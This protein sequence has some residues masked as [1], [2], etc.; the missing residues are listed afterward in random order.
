MWSLVIAKDLF[1]TFDSGNLLDGER[2][3]V[4]RQAIL[5]PGGSR[6]AKALVETYLGRPWSADAWERWMNGVAR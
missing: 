4:Y 6:P 5:V 3:R 2:G 1:S